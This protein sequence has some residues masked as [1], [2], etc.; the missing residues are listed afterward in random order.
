MSS[1]SKGG[2]EGV[3]ALEQRDRNSLL[4]VE[5]LRGVNIRKV[6]RP[7]RMTRTKPTVINGDDISQTQVDQ[8]LKTRS[9][10]QDQ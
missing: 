5:V 2:L 9:K 1:D 10:T 8:C 6:S 3:T 4:S 7:L